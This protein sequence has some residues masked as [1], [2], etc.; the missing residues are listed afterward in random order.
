MSTRTKR[1]PKYLKNYHCNLN[2]SNISSRV[3]YP[4]NLFLSYN[5]LSPFYKFFIMSISSHV[6]SNIYPE[7]MKYDC[8]K[9]VIQ[10]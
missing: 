6:E 10:C 9:N 1:S 2:V 3:I 7:A 4:L 5:K 8:W